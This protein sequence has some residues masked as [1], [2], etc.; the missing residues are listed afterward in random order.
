MKTRKMPL[1]CLLFLILLLSMPGSVLAAGKKSVYVLTSFSNG[2]STTKLT[3]NRNGL[4]S[5][6]TIPSASFGL[7][8]QKLTAS[9][10]AKGLLKKVSISDYNLKHTH[11][12]SYKSGKIAKHKW[13]TAYTSGGKDTLT[14][15][16]KWKG[17]TFTA[18]TKNSGGTVS[19]T[20]KGKLNSKKRLVSIQNQPTG[21]YAGSKITYKYDAKGFLK[22]VSNTFELNTETVKVKNTV[23]K[24]RLTKTVKSTDPTA[25]TFKYKKIK[26]PATYAKL[27]QA[28]QSYL[29]NNIDSFL[30]GWYWYHFEHPVW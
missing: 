3:Y 9:Y 20:A 14:T 7:P 23:K 8:A 27:V 21:D 4:L 18:T 28:Q 10:T 1:I 29:V 11:T 26:V 24:G 6:A 15:T 12:F 5:K 19:D 25:C 22:S 2:V 30:V 16:Y 17:K 13:V